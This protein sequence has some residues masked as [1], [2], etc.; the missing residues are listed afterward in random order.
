MTTIKR[1][2]KYHF[3]AVI[4]GTRHR[5]SLGTSDSKVASRL[6]NRISFALADGAKSPVWS[7]LRCALPAS[8]FKRLS[9]G[10]LPPD[11]LNLTELEQKF[12]DHTARRQK[13]GQI[14]EQ[15]RRNYDRII[16][17]FFD[18]AMELGLRKI[19]ELSPEVVENYLLWRKE[20][21]ISKGGD[22]TGIASDVVVLSSLFTFAVAEG[23]L[24]KTPLKMKPKISPTGGTVQPFTKE[25]MTALAGADKSLLDSVVFTILKNT[26]LRCGDV[27]NLRWS[28]I[29][30]KTGTLRTLT[31]KRQK[32]VEIPMNLEFV[33]IMD[34]FHQKADEFKLPHDDED[35]VFPGLVPSRLYR[36]ARE[37]GDK[38]SVKNCHPHRFRHTFICSMLAK[39]LTLFDAAQLVGDTTATVEKYYAKWTSGQQERVRGI[40]ESK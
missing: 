20:A 4:G 39:G 14:G 16:K 36:M 6:A 5:C 25:E 26:G 8:S 29:D 1:G 38:A 15:S 32:P 3:D 30:W 28:A 27:T 23:W 35:W 24:V 37:W 17:L 2:S 18:R 10:L 31:A 22:G 13:F 34:E 9:D 11:P 33:R 21:I 40:M 12:Y 19:S 7:E